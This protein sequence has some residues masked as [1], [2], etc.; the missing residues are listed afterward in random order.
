MSL[1]KFHCKF[2]QGPK[3][4]KASIC[5]SSDNGLAP[6]QWWHSLLTQLCVTRPRWINSFKNI[7]YF[8]SLVRH[9][10]GFDMGT[11][12]Q[13]VF[14]THWPLRDVAVISNIKTSNT[15]WGVD[16]LSIQRNITLAWMLENLIDDKSPPVYTMAWDSDLWRY[17][18]SLWHNESMQM[19]IF[20]EK[21]V[22]TL[23]FFR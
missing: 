23:F 10:N 7:M 11:G 14:S 9:E 15:T 19:C 21:F 8:V 12:N 3:W 13:I 5:S 6:N 22:W 16:I 4:Q 18:A 17:M 2:A 1:L 20:W